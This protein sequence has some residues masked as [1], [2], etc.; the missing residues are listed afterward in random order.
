[1]GATPIEFIP[2]EVNNEIG[3]FRAFR[4]WVCEN[5]EEQLRA[6]RIYEKVNQFE[7][8]TGKP[9]DKLKAVYEQIKEAEYNLEKAKELTLA[10]FSEIRAER[11]ERRGRGRGRAN[12]GSN[13]AENGQQ[14]E[15]N[16]EGSGFAEVQGD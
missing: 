3:D 1:M 5:Y 4:A 16:N 13:E 14:T 9:I 6:K 7:E 15:G 12:N 2:N 8:P 11:A 10:Y